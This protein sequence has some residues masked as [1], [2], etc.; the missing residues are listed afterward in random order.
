MRDSDRQRGQH[1]RTRRDDPYPA[2]TWIGF[3]KI[4]LGPTPPTLGGVKVH[5]SNSEEA[6][7]EIEF[8]WAGG[9]D[10]VLAAYVFGVRIPF[11][12]GGP[13]PPPPNPHTTYSR[14]TFTASTE[15]KHVLCFTFFSLVVNGLYNRQT[16]HED[17]HETG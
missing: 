3:E 17:T 4:T 7:L 8:S 16:R 12:R 9:M 15:A 6:M 5:G 1:G 10:V 14:S 13:P 11:R 2:V